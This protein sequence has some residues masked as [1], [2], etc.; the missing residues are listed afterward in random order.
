MTPTHSTRR[1][2]LRT[3]SKAYRNTK[4]TS[5]R[6]TRL[7]TIGTRLHTTSYH[8]SWQRARSETLTHESLSTRPKSSRGSGRKEDRD[9]S[10]NLFQANH[11]RPH[12]IIIDSG[13][14]TCGT[15]VKSQ[16]KNLRPT[17]LTVSA[18][19]GSDWLSIAFRGCDSV[20]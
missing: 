5:S 3:L 19:F 4:K 20:S 8:A 14:S 10:L 6:H 17:S 13:A 16:L 9:K 2:K 7:R 12:K 1:R 18:A 11:R 15:G